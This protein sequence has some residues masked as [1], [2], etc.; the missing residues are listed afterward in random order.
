MGAVQPKYLIA[1]ALVVAIAIGVKLSNPHRKYS[2]RE[3]WRDA[4]VETVRDV[5]QEALA[6]GNKNGSV[7]M[8][9]AMGAD[10]PGV[11]V[12]LVERGADVN[13]HDRVFGGTPLSGAAGHSQSP[14]IIEQLVELGAD[15]DEPV[16]NGETPLMIAAR[17]NT[18][19]SIV[20][21]LIELG[22]DVT[23]E[24]AQGLTA[25]DV[26]NTSGN[27]AAATV[28]RAVLGAPIPTR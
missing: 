2:T 6:P 21:T 13:E 4:T 3:F 27:E 10:D 28:L 23:R 11:I 20:Q 1:L 12:A 22:A 15:I 5:P 8:W 9:A 25:L 24:N 14:A 17:Y 16:N 19:P 7:L 18:D 26:A